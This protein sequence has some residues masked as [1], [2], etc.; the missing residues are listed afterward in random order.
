MDCILP[1]PNEL[2]CVSYW[3]VFDNEL[4][5]IKP[6]VEKSSAVRD[7]SMQ[8]HFR[9]FYCQMEHFKTMSF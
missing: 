2:K 7:I 8:T 1:K 6:E 5:F 3:N 4:A 9:A